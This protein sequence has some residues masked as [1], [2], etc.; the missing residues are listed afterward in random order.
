MSAGNSENLPWKTPEVADLAWAIGSSS[1]VAPEFAD[2][3]EG[4]PPRISDDDWC[5]AQLHAMRDELRGMDENPSQLRALI[6]SR[7]DQRLGA[8][9]EDLLGFWLEASSAYELI[10]HRLAVRVDG[11]TLGEFDFIVRDRVSGEYEHWEVAVKFY[12]GLSPDAP[13][14]QWIG[15]GRQDTL[16]K[17]LR[18]LSGKQLRLTERPE[19]RARLEALGIDDI[20]PRLFLKGRLFYPAMAPARFKPECQVPQGVNPEHL[21]GWWCTESQFQANGNDHEW[22]PLTKFDWLTAYESRP[23]PVSRAFPLHFPLGVIG[24]D[25]HGAPSRG[26]IVPDGW[27]NG[28]AA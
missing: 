8:Y 13:W 10:A 16:E 27:L 19:T 1:L 26:F 15:P 18:H 7:K 11:R 25:E 12:L 22:Q 24:R 2:L 6:A 20:H 17:K 9:F 4:V 3:C 5:K 28:G 21:S 14:S 23:G